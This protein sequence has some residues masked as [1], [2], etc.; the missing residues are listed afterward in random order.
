MTMHIKMPT[1]YWP[2]S[3]SNNCTAAEFS[4]RF[5]R[6]CLKPQARPWA[7]IFANHGGSYFLKDLELIH[8]VENLSNYRNVK[9]E[10]NIFGHYTKYRPR[11]LTKHFFQHTLGLRISSRRLLKLSRKLLVSTGGNQLELNH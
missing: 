2:A 10:I 11:T 3:A 6:H 5:L 1:R 9:E 4:E 7:A 8:H